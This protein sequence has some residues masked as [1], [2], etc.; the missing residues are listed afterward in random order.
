M[1]ERVGTTNTR[2]Y[3]HR[4]HQGSVTKITNSGGSVV[5]ALAFDAWGLRRDA[6]DW[7]SL[8]SP[9]AG[10]HET[11]RG[12]TGHEHLDTVGLIH[13]NGRV[14]DPI[15][16]RFISADPIIQDPYSTQ[17]HNRYSYVWNNPASLTDPSGFC[18][19]DD[20]WS[21]CT[22]DQLMSGLMNLAYTQ[23]TD[24][25]MHLQEAA[26]YYGIDT[27]FAQ[28]MAHLDFGDVSH[29]IASLF[30]YDGAGAGSSVPN[31]GGWE[32]RTLGR[33][34]SSSTVP[35]RG[36]ESGDGAAGSFMGQQSSNSSPPAT[37]QGTSGSSSGMPSSNGARRR[38]SR[39]ITGQV[40]DIFIANYFD[41]RDA[42]TIGG[43]KYFHCKANCEAAQLGPLA[44]N[45]AESFSNFREFVDRLTGD[46]PAASAA[47]Q[48]ANEVGRRGGLA[49]PGGSCSI[50]C[51][52][53][54][55]N[56]LPPQ[57]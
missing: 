9:F 45:Q 44:A 19:V 18:T 32:Q 26:M 17:S 39:A 6:T 23:F 46:P 29:G 24:R 35:G 55:P 48:N 51:D 37:S 14:Q 22:E 54:R 20:G 13:M 4:D 3:L 33:D 49:N 2:Q 12:Y 7:S 53:F 57:Y 43:D 11:E 25:L 28:A 50:I 31:G 15:L 34:G 1:L 42:N 30:G 52:Q 8:G 56:G 40:R 27:G 36:Y 41:M 21:D 38:A 10:S 16:G 5:Q 47:D